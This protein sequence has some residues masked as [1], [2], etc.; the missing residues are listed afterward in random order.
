MHSTLSNKIVAA[1]VAAVFCATVTVGALLPAQTGV[2]KEYAGGSWYTSGEDWDL[3][4]IAYGVNR[5]RGTGRGRINFCIR[6][7]KKWKKQM[8]KIGYDN[9]KLFTNRDS[10]APDWRES[11]E[12]HLYVDAADFAFICTH[13]GPGYFLFNDD[14]TAEEVHWNETHWGDQ[15]VEAVA[16]QSCQTLRH[17][18]IQD[19]ANQH[20]DAGVHS[21]LGYQ[22]NAWDTGRVGKYYGKYLRQGY[23]VWLAWRMGTKKAEWKW[24]NRASRLQYVSSTCDTWGN[25]AYGS[26]CDPVSN[27]EIYWS[28]WTL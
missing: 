2:A 10:D 13:G 23:A 24:Y 4:Q 27:S 14:G 20:R 1:S 15:D 25:T 16:M 21:I 12:D 11:Q 6:G 5:W 19:F 8:K 18:F 22:D 28:Y 26:S 7:A 9:Y 17:T 3:E